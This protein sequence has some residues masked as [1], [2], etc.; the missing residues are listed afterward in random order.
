MAVKSDIVSKWWGLST[1]GIGQIVQGFNHVGQCINL[2]MNTQKG[3]DPLRPDFGVDLL[4][5]IDGPVNSAIPALINEIRDQIGRY[6]KRATILSITSTLQG[7]ANPVISV[8]WEFNNAIGNS[9]L[10]L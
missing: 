9:T 4:A 7:D 8:D 1:Q 3:S 5:Y 2:V 10:N 6:E